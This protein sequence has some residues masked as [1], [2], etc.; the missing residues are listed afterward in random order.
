MEK[1]FGRGL[2]DLAENRLWELCKIVFPRNFGPIDS[3]PMCHSTL[4]V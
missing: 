2:L 4:K 1:L 3:L